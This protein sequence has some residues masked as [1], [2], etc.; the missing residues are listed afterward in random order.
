MMAWHVTR[1]S[2]RLQGHEP[3]LTPLHIIC[4]NSEA[5]KEVVQCV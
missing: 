2:F 1:L 5:T 4:R 3:G